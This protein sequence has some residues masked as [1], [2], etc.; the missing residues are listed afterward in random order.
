ML[1]FGEAGF[2]AMLISVLVM[3]SAFRSQY[4][5]NEP[6][7][8]LPMMLGATFGLYWVGA[9]LFGFT[10]TERYP[11]LSLWM[12]YTVSALVEIA[13]TIASFYFWGI[14]FKLLGLKQ[15]SALQSGK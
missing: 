14:V 2:L 7:K 11:G 15:R 6:D 4:N 8:D 5:S 9:V 10:M 13:M 3:G 1:T 12:Y